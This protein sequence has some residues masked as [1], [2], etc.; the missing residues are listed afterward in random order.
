M[1]ETSPTTQDVLGHVMTELGDITLCHFA[2][3]FWTSREYRRFD[4]GRKTESRVPISRDS[5]AEWFAYCQRRGAT[6]GSFPNP[7]ETP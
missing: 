6:F 5:A 7:E 4:S 3:A 2:G 1:L